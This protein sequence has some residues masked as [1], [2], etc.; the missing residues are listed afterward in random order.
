MAANHRA[1]CRARSKAEFCAKLGIV[2]EEI[3]ES[4]FWLEL[5]IESGLIQADRLHDLRNEA[6]ELTAIFTSAYHTSK[7]RKKVSV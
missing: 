7:R 5:L 2:V 4:L 6:D 1:A 3:D